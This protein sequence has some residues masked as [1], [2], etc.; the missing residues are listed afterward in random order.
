MKSFRLGAI[1]RIANKFKIEAE[2]V[3]V[4]R[5]EFTEDKNPDVRSI[6]VKV[7]FEDSEYSGT[8]YTYEYSTWF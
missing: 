6:R 1:E 8:N 2:H 3:E 5:M 4:T 7:T